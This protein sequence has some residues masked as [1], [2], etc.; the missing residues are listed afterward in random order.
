MVISTGSLFSNPSGNRYSDEKTGSD[1]ASDD[2]RSENLYKSNYSASIEIAGVTDIDKLGWSSFQRP[3]IWHPA[4]AENSSMPKYQDSN[5]GYPAR[6]GGYCFMDTAAA[7]DRMNGPGLEEDFEMTSA[8]KSTGNASPV[9][10]ILLMMVISI[11]V[12]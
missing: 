9:F 1:V 4:F 11:L 3:E 2:A 6:E 8:Q 5:D 12:M 7:H 10:F